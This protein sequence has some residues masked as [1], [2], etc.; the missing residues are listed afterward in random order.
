MSPEISARRKHLDIPVLKYFVLRRISHV[1]RNGGSQNVL[2]NVINYLSLIKRVKAL[3][4]WE[5]VWEMSRIIMLIDD[6]YDVH[7]PLF[8]NLVT[9]EVY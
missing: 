8:N 3:K 5:Q 2:I 9:S 7:I 1:N 4:V 6:N